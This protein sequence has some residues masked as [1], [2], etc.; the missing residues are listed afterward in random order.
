MYPVTLPNSWMSSDSFLVESLGFSRYSIMSSANSVSFTLSFQ[1]GF[2]LFI[3]LL[4]LP[5]LGLPKLCWRVV[6]RVDILVLFLNLEGILLSFHNWEWCWLWFC[7]IWP[8]LCW[9]RFS[10]WPLSERFLSEMFVD[11]VRSFFCVYWENHIVFILQFVTVGCHTDWYAD[12][13]KSLHPWDK[14][15]LVMMNNPFNVLLDEVC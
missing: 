14:S 15:H 8:L 9:G 11:F 13:E 10:L 12:I 5:W 6:A 7:H 1:L 2:L 3:F 4:W